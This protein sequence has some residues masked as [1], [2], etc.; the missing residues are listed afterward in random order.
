MTSAY[1]PIKPNRTWFLV[2]LGLVVAELIYLALVYPSKL[3]T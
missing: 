1:P 3:L 2:V